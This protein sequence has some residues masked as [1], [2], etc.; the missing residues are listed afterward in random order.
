MPSAAAARSSRPWAASASRS[1]RSAALGPAATRLV[2]HS[3]LGE[4]LLELNDPPIRALF[5]AANNPAVTCPDAGTVRRALSRDDLFTVVHDPFLSDTARYADLVLPA[6]TYLESED[7]F[8]AYGTYYVQFAPRAVPPQ[9]EAW[10]NRP[11]R[12]GAGAAPRRQG[13]RLL[14][15]HR[16]ARPP[17]FVGAT[18]P[19][20]GVD[21]DTLRTAGPVKID[22]YP[23][24]Q[25]FRTPSGKLEFYSASARRPGPARPCPTGARTPRRRRSAGAGRC[26][27]SPRPATSR[28]TRPSRA[29]RRSGGAKGAPVVVLH[30]D[31]AGAAG[32]GPTT[33]SSSSTT[34]AGSACA[35]ACR[36]EVA[37]GVALVPGQRPAGEAL[38]GTINMLCSDRLS[39]PRRGRDL[40]E[41]LPR[42]P[43]PGSDFDF[44]TIHNPTA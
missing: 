43:P 30:P 42:R 31:D 44:L 32:S 9:G 16:R 3:R 1:R 12:P 37:P 23:D 8:R 25:R 29:S 36:D 18:G 26:A 11:A 17:A 2:N 7:L 20:A 13:R 40:P 5:V 21:P 6:T 4:A 10:S 39:R 22:P 35:S 15:D 41:H 33:A 34:G 19:A 27:S 38:A 14:H 28:A 24:G